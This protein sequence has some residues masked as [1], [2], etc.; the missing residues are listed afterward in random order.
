MPCAS[1]I[2]LLPLIFLLY[3][4]SGWCNLKY[5]SLLTLT[6]QNASLILTIRYSRTLPGDMYIATTAVVL[7]EVFK[8]LACLLIILAEKRN[9]R[10]WLEVLYSTIIG[11]PWD[12]LKLSVPAL[13]YTVQNNLQYVAISNLDAAT[14]QVS[15]S[16]HYY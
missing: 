10:D 3:S 1:Y 2:L 12:T 5:I 7:S 14:F 6:I 9:V 11:Q 8:V 15:D 4:E 13:I 16:N